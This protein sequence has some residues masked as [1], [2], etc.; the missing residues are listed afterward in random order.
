MLGFLWK[1]FAIKYT[2]KI[3]K[4]KVYISTTKNYLGKWTGAFGSSTTVA[5]TYWTMTDDMNKAFTTKTGSITWELDSATSK[6]IQ[7]N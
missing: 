7:Q 4:V 5:P 2:E 6:I 1:D 3:V